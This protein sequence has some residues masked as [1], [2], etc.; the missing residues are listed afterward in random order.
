MSSRLLVTVGVRLKPGLTPL[1]TASSDWAEAR[2][3]R[4]DKHSAT[5]VYNIVVR[6]AE[7]TKVVENEC[8]GD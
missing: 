3:T 6:A 8:F 2:R 5:L 7:E 1:K 4:E